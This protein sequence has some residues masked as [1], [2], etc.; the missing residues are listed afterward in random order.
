M[1]MY[2]DLSG[3]DV[4]RPADRLPRWRV[5]CYPIVIRH[6]AILLVQP[7]WAERWELPGGGVQ[8][9]TEESLAQAATRE[10]LEETGCRIAVDASSLRFVEEAFFSVAGN[11]N[12]YHSLVF[13]ILGTVIDDPASDWTPEASEIVRV[14][15]IPL[16][17]LATSILH[18]LHRK[19]IT[20]RSIVERNLR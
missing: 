13:S 14:A 19:A 15:W 3:D 6:G 17:D 9:E 4:Q 7:V 5:S 20:D 8:L 16:L 12:Y 2:A 1:P 11:G 18:P 10:C